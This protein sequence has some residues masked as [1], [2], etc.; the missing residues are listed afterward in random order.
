MDLT[1][2]QFGI[3]QYDWIISLEVAE[4]IPEKYEAVYLDNIF[5]HAKEGIILSW[6]VPGQGGLSHINNKPIEYVTKVM[7]DNGFKR[8]A[9]KTMKLQTSA[10]LSWI[11]SNINV[12]VRNTHSLIGSEGRSYQWFT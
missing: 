12:Y 4:H 2:P 5:R 11:K 8:D 10:S 6:A 3:R 9:E 7:R 1:I